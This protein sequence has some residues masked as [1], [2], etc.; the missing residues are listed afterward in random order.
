[1]IGEN[2]MT[3]LRYY[4]FTWIYQGIQTTAD[5]DGIVGS[6]GNLEEASSS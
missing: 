5:C 1:L 4:F 3:N 2:S 6:K